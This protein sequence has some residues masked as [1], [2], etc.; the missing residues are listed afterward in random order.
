MLARCTLTFLAIQAP[1][2]SKVCGICGKQ[3]LTEN[4]LLKEDILDNG[5]LVA[6]EA[7]ESPSLL[8]LLLTAFDKC[9]Y[10]AGKFVS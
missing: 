1:G 5:D 3:Y 6:E 2:I 4:Y 10:C 9:I 7:F 8:Q